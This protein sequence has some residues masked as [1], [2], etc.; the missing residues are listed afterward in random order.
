MGKLGLRIKLNTDDDIS[1]NHL[2]LFHNRI[3]KNV[4]INIIFYN[5]QIKYDVKISGLYFHVVLAILAA[6]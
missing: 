3:I 6:A 4:R 2:Y 1:N 5:V